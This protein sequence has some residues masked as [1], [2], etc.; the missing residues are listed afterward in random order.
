MSQSEDTKSSSVN[1][2][3]FIRIVNW[4]SE[5][6]QVGYSWLFPK[7][8]TF[9]ENESGD[10]IHR[11]LA[12]KSW[13]DKISSGW[14]EQPFTDKLSIFAGAALLPML[15]GLLVGAPMLLTSFSLFILGVVHVSLVAHEH[16]R[17]EQATLFSEETIALNKD[18]KATEKL[19]KKGVN[20]GKHL[21]DELSKQSD[22]IKTNAQA[23][24]KKSEEIHEQKEEISILIDEMKEAVTGLVT[25]EKEVHQVLE[26]ATEKL[27]ALDS[28]VIQAIEHVDG[29]G[30]EAEKLSG[31]VRELQESNIAFAEAAKRF[32]IFVEQQKY[33]V[34]SAISD[35]DFNSLNELQDE[36]DEN[37][38]LIQQMKLPMGRSSHLKCVSGH[39]R[40]PLSR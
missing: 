9:P 2:W 12:N 23:L 34:I 14:V 40:G 33:P 24:E 1:P 21:A 16:H 26:H 18:L 31:T 4:I 10:I 38:A 25:Q 20:M 29:V 6:A 22:Q 32:G 27:S 28:A 5:I 15:V 3:L 17:I 35:E 11:V 39:N 30:A 37:N 13:F 7:Q 8:K 19:F 36:L